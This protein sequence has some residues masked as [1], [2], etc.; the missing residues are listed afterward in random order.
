M[1]YA[2]SP[3]ETVRPPRTAAIVAVVALGI[4]AL[5]LNILAVLAA[6]GLIRDGGVA[7]DGA[8]AI[9]TV[10][11]IALVVLAG[12]AV[13]AWLWQARRNADV[14]DDLAHD[15]GRPWVIAGWIVPLLNLWVPRSVVLGVWRASAPAG[16]SAWPVNA[17]WTL[18]LVGVVG[19]RVANLDADGGF[20]TILFPIVME[21]AALA[22]QLAMLIIWRVTRYQE[23]HAVRLR[24]A[25][26]LGASPQPL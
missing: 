10:A 6:I 16:T 23:A 2:S 14:I 3:A 19:G 18:W 22:A 8:V 11:D 7:P 9:G 4:N 13:I 21:I 17:W 26:T 12:V 15:W 25:L 1:T 5:F 24:N 20:Q